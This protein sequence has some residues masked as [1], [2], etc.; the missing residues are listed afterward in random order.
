MTQEAFYETIEANSF[1]DRVSPTLP[2][3]D[4]LRKNKSEIL[5]KLIN[6]ISLE[7]LNVLEVGCF[8]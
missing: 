7:S 6:N 2:A 4:V 1:F 8:I 3:P 5:N